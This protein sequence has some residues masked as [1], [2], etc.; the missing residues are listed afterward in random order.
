MKTSYLRRAQKFL[1]KSSRDLRVKTYAEINKLKIKP[2]SGKKLKGR[3]INL[4]SH[5]FRY[6]GNSYRI[7]YRIEKGIIV[8]YIAGRENFYNDL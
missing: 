8:V 5:R 1:D 3:H 4:R 6:K 7:A 2:Y